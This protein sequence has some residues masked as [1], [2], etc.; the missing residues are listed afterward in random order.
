[1]INIGHVGVGTTT[2]KYTVIIRNNNASS[3]FQITTDATGEI[4]LVV[5]SDSGFEGTTTL[6]Y[7]QIDVAFNAV[8]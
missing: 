1:M 3:S 8:D 4:W 6:Y 5:G 7:T 2:T